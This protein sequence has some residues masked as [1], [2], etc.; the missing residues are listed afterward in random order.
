MLVESCPMK[1]S[2]QI[3]LNKTKNTSQVTDFSPSTDGSK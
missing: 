3:N 2:I 1:N